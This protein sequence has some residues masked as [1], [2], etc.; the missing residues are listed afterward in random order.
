LQEGR[1][2]HRAAVRM[3]ASGVPV[4]HQSWRSATIGSTPA[5]R[6]AGR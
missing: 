6:R 1:R 4:T 3:H 5:A 2:R